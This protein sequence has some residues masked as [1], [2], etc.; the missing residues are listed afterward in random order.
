MKAKS[1]KSFQRTLFFSVVGVFLLLALF[2]SVYQYYREKEYKVD[3]M[4]YRLQMYNYE[5]YHFVEETGTDNRESFLNFVDGFGE[6]GLRATLI[7][8]DGKVLMDSY[9]PSVDSMDNHLKR[10]EVQTALKRGK[11]YEKRRVSS[12]DGKSMYYVATAF[13]NLIVRTAVPYSSKLAKTLK[14]DNYYLFYA[15]YIKMKGSKVYCF[16]YC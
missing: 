11:G 13:P 7:G 15:L 8:R 5:I 16:L 3:T 6:A 2:F 9:L 4:N 10:E 12:A 14:V 1:R